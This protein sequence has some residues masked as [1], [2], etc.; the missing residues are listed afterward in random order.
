[1][2]LAQ[3]M[4]MGRPCAA[5][6]GLLASRGLQTARA[7]F[8]AGAPAAASSSPAPSSSAAAAATGCSPAATAAAAAAV[9]TAAASA[10]SHHRRGAVRCSSSGGGGA[11]AAS[12]SAAGGIGGRENIVRVLRE[13]GL[14]AEVTSDEL[15]AAAAAGPLSV[16]C[17]FD[18]T[19][20]SLH[21]GN[22]LGIIVLSWFQRCGH[23]PVALLGGATGRVGDPS[24]RS[25][26]RPILSEEEIERNVAAIGGLLR[27]I[28]ARGGAAA[29]AAAPPV[30]VV[31]N[32][33]WF[34][35]MSFLSFLRDVGKSARVGAMLAKDSVRSR[36]E[37]EQGLSF[38]EFTYQLLQARE[39]LRVLL[40]V[41]VDACVACAARDVLRV[42]LLRAARSPGARSRSRTPGAAALRSRYRCWEGPEGFAVGRGAAES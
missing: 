23:A 40:R 12:A 30:A 17:G 41:V 3:K 27:A 28:L 5:G 10:R 33:D 14:I 38:T 20:D 29:G 4:A 35:G 9:S 42:L 32:L 34:G 24:G 22:L 37:A 8:P 7:L 13:R 36:M 11:V 31:N 39:I 6:A 25:T 26:E 16:Y 21:L 1:M 18:P 19:A 2:M 15:E